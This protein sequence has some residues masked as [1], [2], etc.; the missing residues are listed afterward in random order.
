MLGSEGDPRP[1][2]A[3]EWTAWAACGWTLCPSMSA[4]LRSQEKARQDPGALEQHQKRDV[5]MKRN[6]PDLC[7]VRPLSG[8]TSVEKQEGLGR[9]PGK[10][11]VMSTCLGS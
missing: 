5:A 9:S 1:Q 2:P 6:R 10:S 11:T 7:S 8:V 4:S 3:P